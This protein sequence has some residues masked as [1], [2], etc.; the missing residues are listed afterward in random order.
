MPLPLVTPIKEQTL[1]NTRLEVHTGVLQNIHI[2][3]DGSRWTHLLPGL[4]MSG[5]IHASKAGTKISVVAEY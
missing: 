2:F 5:A 1:I 4:R 3:W